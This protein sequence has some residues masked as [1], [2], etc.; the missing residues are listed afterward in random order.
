MLNRRNF[1]ARLSGALAAFGLLP[2]QGTQAAPA[3]PRLESPAGPT[4][5][6]STYLGG[7]GSPA[8]GGPAFVPG[9]TPSAERAPDRAEPGGLTEPPAP[10]S[11][12][13]APDPRQP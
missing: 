8:P 1:F 11:T 10:P 2:R 9:R 3:P 13:S 4:L 5:V 7:T 6:Y 12:G